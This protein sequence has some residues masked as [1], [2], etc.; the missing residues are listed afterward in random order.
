MRANA[1][2][3]CVTVLVVLAVQLLL[4]LTIFQITFGFAHESLFWQTV[5]ALVVASFV[6]GSLAL[7]RK[8]S[9]AAH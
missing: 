4:D 5:S 6:T 1:A 2:I 8:T 9:P 7:L 3:F